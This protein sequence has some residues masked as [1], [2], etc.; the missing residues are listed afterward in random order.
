MWRACSSDLNL[1]IIPYDSI[2]LN[3]NKFV[4]HPNQKKTGHWLAVV[5]REKEKKLTWWRNGLFFLLLIFFFIS[6]FFLYIFF[7]PRCNDPQARNN[8]KNEFRNQYMYSNASPLSFSFF[9]SWRK[10]KK[11]KERKKESQYPTRHDGLFC[12]TARLSR[13]LFDLLHANVFWWSCT[14]LK[15]TC[16]RGIAGQ[17]DS[18]WR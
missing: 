11:K 14:K 6:S 18:V 5:K 10:G 9:S 8:E 13:I 15:R 3:D 4:Q 12:C 17:A 7:S 2:L 1:P 16:K